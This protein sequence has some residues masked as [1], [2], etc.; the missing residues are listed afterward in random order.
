MLKSLVLCI[1]IC[2]AS[3]YASPLHVPNKQAD[4]LHLPDKQANPL[5]LPDKR[6]NSL[7]PLAKQV[8]SLHLP[9]K[10]ADSLHPPTKQA[11]PLHLP[12]QQADPTH[13]PEKQARYQLGHSICVHSSFFK[14]HDIIL[15]FCF[16]LRNKGT[17]RCATI[18]I[19]LNTGP[20]NGNIS[21][22]MWTR[23]FALTSFTPLPT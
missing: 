9:D 4:P 3:T 12:D 15:I 11:N 19:G 1:L 8:K 20:P 2:L 21:R 5:H 14:V 7:H 22:K 16:L 23:I 10:R 13:L 6:A 17:G 18:P